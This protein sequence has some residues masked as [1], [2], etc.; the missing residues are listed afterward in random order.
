MWRSCWDG[1]IR[2]IFVKSALVMFPFSIKYSAQLS[3]NITSNEYELVLNYIKEFV[4]KK[5]ADDV[6][7]WEN[8][9]E[10]K[11]RLFRWRSRNNIMS[12]IDKGEFYILNKENRT[13]LI[14]EIYMY[15][16]LLSALGFAVI[17]G[18]ITRNSALSAFV[19]LFMGGLNWL[20]AI[21]RHKYMLSALKKKINTLISSEVSHLYVNKNN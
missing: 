12:S 19:L 17:I 2:K 6:I 10:F 11:S 1:K 5:T 8:G 13:I 14:Y 9:L 4:E 20:V 7:V 3:G 21:I 18:I 15:F 16:L